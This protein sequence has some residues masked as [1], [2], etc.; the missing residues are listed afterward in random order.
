MRSCLV[1][2]HSFE[3]DDWQCPSCG[4]TPERI[5]KHL[6]FAPELAKDNDGYPAERYALMPPLKKEHFWRKARNRLFIWSLHRYFPEA[7][8]LLEIGSGNGA[9][10]RA[11]RNEFPNLDVWGSDLYVTGLGAIEENVPG[12]TVFQADARRLPFHE[13]FSVV[14]AF[15]VLEH[16]E[17]D[18]E[19][20]KEM[21]KTTRPNG[22]ILLSVPQHPFLWS[23]RDEA[24]SHKRRYTRAELLS[25]V[26]RSGFEV[27]R[28]TSFITF[29]FPLMI[30]SSLRNKK[31]RE[32]YNPWAE[33][34]IGAPL[35]MCLDSV[36]ACERKAIELGISFPFGGSLFLAARRK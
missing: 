22:G 17:K 6:A 3:A 18:L 7:S 26:E 11:F 21:H 31:K 24:L 23:Q 13:E 19:V 16:I 2:G 33:L 32:N 34:T 35:S 8:S 12:A 36:L 1:C 4:R 15:D 10:L 25:K 9:V 5:G 30:L 20:L 14:A 29:P 27:L 28:I